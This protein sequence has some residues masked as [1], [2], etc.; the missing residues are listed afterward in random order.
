MARRS[1]H[2]RLARG[3]RREH[4]A[5]DAGRPPPRLVCSLPVVVTDDDTGTLE[6]ISAA[7]AAQA[8]HLS[9]RTVLDREGVTG[10]ADV[11]V[12]GREE[13]V[14][15]Q[16]EVIIS[17]GATEFSAVEL[18]TNPDEA[19]RTRAVLKQ[20]NSEAK[21]GLAGVGSGREVIEKA[22]TARVPAEVLLCQ[23]A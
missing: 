18:G 11:A 3:T 5:Q 6:R 13:S 17:A 20:L 9:Y 1:K 14:R 12:I 19:A 4:C 22:R 21:P 16:L 15:E 2:D 23:R 8:G 10:P 7:L